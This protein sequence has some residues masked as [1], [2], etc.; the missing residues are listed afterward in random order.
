MIL[1]IKEYQCTR[2]HTKDEAYAILEILGEALRE[3]L[4]KSNF[5]ASVEN[6]IKIII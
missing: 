3:D 2:G 4:N 6:L 1:V 5:R